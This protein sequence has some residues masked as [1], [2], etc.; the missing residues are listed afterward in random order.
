MVRRVFFS[1]H[2][3]R[4]VWRASQVRNRWV[5][6]KDTETTGYVDAA[7][8]EEV[9]Q[10]GEEAIKSWIDEQLYGTSV[11]VVLIGRETADR[12]Y[13]KYEIAQS[14]RRGNG[15]VGIKIHDLKNRN[16]K[17]DVSG[18]NPLDEFV[19]EGPNGVTKLTDIFRTYDW[20]LDNGRDNIGIWVE[21]ARQ[22]ADCLSPQE[23][24]SVRERETRGLGISRN[25]AVGAAA[26]GLLM[27]WTKKRNRSSKSSLNAVN[28]PQWKSRNTRSNDE[29]W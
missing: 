11:T 9:K 22:R 29:I 8:W 1:F 3:T 19:V 24:Q 21:E 2:Y 25:T 23:R 17:Q 14:I 4:D 15:I 7:E 13:V 18:S 6:K 16:R 28:E 5:T 26:L 12:K 10:D 27:W 20:N